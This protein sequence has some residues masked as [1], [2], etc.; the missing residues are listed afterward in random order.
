[1][2]LFLR[3]S[4]GQDTVALPAGKTID[5]VTDKP[6]RARINWH[7]LNAGFH[8]R[9]AEQLDV[10]DPMAAKYHNLAAHS[11]EAAKYAHQEMLPSAEGKSKEAASATEQALSEDARG[12]KPKPKK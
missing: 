3:L 10:K 7:S 2:T 6:N 8:R 12:A 4:K 9:Q 11:H 1:M 5:D